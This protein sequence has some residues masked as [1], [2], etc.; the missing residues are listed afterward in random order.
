MDIE[1]N[2]SNKKVSYFYNQTISKF[3]YSRDHPMKPERIG[4]AHNLIVNFNLYRYN[5]FDFRK[6]DVYESRFSTKDEMTKF[7]SPDYI[8]YL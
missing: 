4:M 8:E 6:L 5:F 2:P 7:H 3:V 1:P